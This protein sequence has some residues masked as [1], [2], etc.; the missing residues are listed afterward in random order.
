[1]TQV[2]ISRGFYD[3][4]IKLGDIIIWEKENDSSFMSHLPWK[5]RGFQKKSIQ[6][7]LVQIL[8]SVHIALNLGFYFDNTANT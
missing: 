4:T 1:M 7:I 8:N 6:L 5:E 3:P 2:S